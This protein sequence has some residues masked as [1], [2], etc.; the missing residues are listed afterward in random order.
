MIFP[1][2][3]E[4]QEGQEWREYNFLHFSLSPAIRVISAVFI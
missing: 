3:E 1:Y 4:R 2:F